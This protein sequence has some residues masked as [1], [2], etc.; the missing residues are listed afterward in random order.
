[1]IRHVRVRR[2]ALACQSSDVWLDGLPDRETERENCC[3]WTTQQQWRLPATFRY[4]WELPLFFDLKSAESRESTFRYE[5]I[6]VDPVSDQRRVSPSVEGHQD[7]GDLLGV[8]R[9]FLGVARMPARVRQTAKKS[10]PVSRAWIMIFRN[11]LRCSDRIKV[12][13]E[14]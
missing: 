11:M 13:E 5:A 6:S 8:V 1:M 12:S 7:Q 14:R 3:E 2:V 4:L 10:S 9:V